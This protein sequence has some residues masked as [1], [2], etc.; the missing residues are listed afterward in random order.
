MSA[1]SVSPINLSPPSLPLIETQHPTR[2]ATTV[3][4]KAPTARGF[5]LAERRSIAFEKLTLYLVLFVAIVA[6]VVSFVAL[7][8]VGQQ[9]MQQQV[10][11]L[12]PL[13]IDG[14]AIACS[15][16]I[17]R[18]QASGEKAGE[19][20]SEWLG[21]F[22]ALGL[23]ILGNVYHGLHTVTAA[24]PQFLVIAYSAAVPIIVAYGIHVYGRAMSRGISAH[25]LADDPDKLHFDVVHLGEETMAQK[26]A[27]ARIAKS[28]PRQVA[29]ASAPRQ[30]ETAR[31][32]VAEARA[33][34][35]APTAPSSAPRQDAPTAPTQLGKSI[36]DAK[37][38]Y[39]Q[40][41]AAE[42]EAGRDVS[43]ADVR[44]QVES[45]GF[46]VPTEGAGRKWVSQIVAELDAIVPPTDRAAADLDAA[47]STPERA[48]A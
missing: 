19:R 25:V 24:V 4:P 11:Y 12:L 23:S 41:V 22:I 13:A 47:R 10:A 6:A 17:V 37:A 8:W 21:M 2:K 33:T 3:A 32:A 48:T 40:I 39:R 42:V 9:F 31:A 44:R 38:R 30:Q 43:A 18:S 29:A 15:V 16:G 45:E 28:A 5:T 27:P 14:F 20:A 35:T 46:E 36:K 34:T 1:V 26:A 7:T